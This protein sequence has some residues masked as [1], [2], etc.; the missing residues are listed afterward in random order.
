[1]HPLVRI[2]PVHG[3]E[4]F[5]VYRFAVRQRQAI[6]ASQCG[7]SVFRFNRDCK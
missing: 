4:P 7:S 1:M 6:L 5:A 3:A 2:F